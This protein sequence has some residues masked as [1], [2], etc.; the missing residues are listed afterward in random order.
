[1][2]DSVIRLVDNLVG[3]GGVLAALPVGRGIPAIGNLGGAEAGARGRL[4]VG[5]VP[6]DLHPGLVILVELK[7]V[8]AALD[9][10]ED[11]GNDQ[12]VP[13][14][15]HRLPD[16][17]DPGRDLGAGDV[18]EPGPRAGPEELREGV[19]EDD[20]GIF[21]EIREIQRRLQFDRF[22]V[23]TVVD[24]GLGHGGPPVCGIIRCSAACLP[25]EVASWSRH[26]DTIDANTGDGWPLP[27]GPTF[28]G[29]TRPGDSLLA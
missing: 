25:L 11:A 15:V 7:N 10:R 4:E 16:A 6:P 22:L 8:L 3:D 17:P 12:F 27:V 2:V 21:R 20:P 5:P 24:V 14:A 1:L 19:A 13:G 26:T 28:P 9:R 29:L 23:P 18:D